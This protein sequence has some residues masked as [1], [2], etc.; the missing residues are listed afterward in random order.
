M[1]PR[2]D[3]TLAGVGDDPAAGRDPGEGRA[4]TPR[5]DG[6]LAGSGR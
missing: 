3:G 5:L 6:T 1:T 2:L 4:M